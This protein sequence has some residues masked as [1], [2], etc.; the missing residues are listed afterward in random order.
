MDPIIQQL[1]AELGQKPQYVENVIRL[2]EW[3]YRN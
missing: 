3:R 1:A 2:L